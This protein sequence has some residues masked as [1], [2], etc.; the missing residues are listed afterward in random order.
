M[1]IAEQQTRRIHFSDLLDM[2]KER[3][4]GTGRVERENTGGTWIALSHYIAD[5]S[6]TRDVQEKI[7]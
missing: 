4:F 7:S 6:H 1:Q 2:L 3:H 5:L